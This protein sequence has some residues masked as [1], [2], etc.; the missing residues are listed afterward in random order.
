MN[1]Q[2]KTTHWAVLLPLIAVF[3]WALNVA[4]T[5]YVADYISPVSISF[6]RWFVAFL[7]LTPFMLMKVIRE[8]HLIQPNLAKL[9]V[10]SAFGMVLYQGISYAA[11][12]YTSATNMG[13]INAFIPIF[14]IFVS[15]VILKEYPNKYAVIGGVLS[16]SGLIFVI[17]QGDI[18]SLVNLGGHV[19]DL[20]MIAAVFFYAFYG[21][22][23][24]KWKLQIPLMLSLYVQII[25]A[26]IYHLPFLL[27]FGLDAI[28]PENAVSVLYAG[29]FPSL[30]APL[31]WMLSIQQNGPNRTS[32]FM[33]LMPVFTAFIAYFWLKEAWTIYHTIGGVIIIV[34][35]LLA[36]KKTSQLQVD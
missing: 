35:I 6:Y 32:V 24:K 1:Q 17:A 30:I 14:T 29:I 5:R 12:H 9:A 7:I 27:W 25:F 3:I 36:Q 21:V 10:L 4:V 28:R 20:L 2:T 26:L 16:F 13:I 8:W 11:A 34:G 22:F 31:I 19:G 23:L 15:M 18:T 33:N